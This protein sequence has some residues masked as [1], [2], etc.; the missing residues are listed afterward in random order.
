MKIPCFGA[1][2]KASPCCV[3]EDQTTDSNPPKARAIDRAR[4]VCTKTEPE[5]K[6][7]SAGKRLEP[8]KVKVKIL[9]NFR[10]IMIF[11]QNHL[12]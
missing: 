4:A 11:Q 2:A 1:L 10:K 12:K 6:I 8:V 9:P 7:D 5:S 3:F